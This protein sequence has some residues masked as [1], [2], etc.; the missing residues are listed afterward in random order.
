MQEI[1]KLLGHDMVPL[2]RLVNLFKKDTMCL[3]SDSLSLLCNTF[4]DNYIRRR[5]A[6]L[7]Y[8]LPPTYLARMWLRE[9]RIW[10]ISTAV[11]QGDAFKKNQPISGRR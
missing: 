1:Q 6:I 9:L 4:Y 2:F 7:M 10:M 8:P 3:L 5:Y 11:L